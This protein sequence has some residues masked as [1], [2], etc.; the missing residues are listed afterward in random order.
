MPYCDIENGETMYIGTCE[1][2]GEEISRP[3]VGSHLCDAC[4]TEGDSPFWS[5]DSVVGEDEWDDVPF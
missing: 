2:C 5:S 3:Y 4:Y 1:V